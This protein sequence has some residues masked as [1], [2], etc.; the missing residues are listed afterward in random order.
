MIQHRDLHW[1]GK[2]AVPRESVDILR[3]TT[4]R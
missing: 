2:R 1:H 3:C 4:P